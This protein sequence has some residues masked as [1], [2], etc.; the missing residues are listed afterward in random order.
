VAHVLH[1]CCEPVPETSEMGTERPVERSQLQLAYLNL[2][3]PLS[4]G[5]GETGHFCMSAVA[6]PTV[7]CSGFRVEVCLNW[8]A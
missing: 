2:R 5:D 1:M 3:W 6:N 4:N 8:R 7:C